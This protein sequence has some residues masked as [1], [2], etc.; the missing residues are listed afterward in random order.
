[1]DKQALVRKHRKHVV[2]IAWRSVTTDNCTPLSYNNSE[3]AGTPDRARRAIAH[4]VVAVLPEARTS[5]APWLAQYEARSQEG[6]DLSNLTFG[7]LGGTSLLAVEAAWRSS[8]SVAM[9][10]TKSGAAPAPPHLELTADDFLRGTLEEAAVTLRHILQMRLCLANVRT[11]SAT[12]VGRAD[13]GLV[14]TDDKPAEF[15]APPA[16]AV[17]QISHASRKRGRLEVRERGRVVQ[18]RS[19]VAIG[20]AGASVRHSPACSGGETDVTRE[21]RGAEGARVEL[22]IRW[23]SCLSKCIDATPLLVIPTDARGMVN[24]TR[25]G[26]SD[27]AVSMPDETPADLPECCCHSKPGGSLPA[28]DAKGSVVGNTTL[29]RN[30]RSSTTQ[31]ERGTVYVGSH[32]GDF[33]ALNLPTGER[34]W[35][36]T[37]NGRIESGAACSCDGLMVFV[38]CHDRH[39]YAI[40]R[41][42]GTLSWSFE[43]GDAIKCTPV[44]M[45]YLDPDEGTMR[46]K[47]LPVNYGTV[48]VGSHDGILRSLRE[49]DGE[50]KWSFDCGGALFASPA[51]SADSR[52]VYAAT[53]KGRVVALDCSTLVSTG[54]KEAD[55]ATNADTKQRRVGLSP[56]QPAI[57]W[58]IHLPA[59]CFS[60]P[61]VCDS[62]GSVVL[63]CVDGGLY[64]LSS[65]GE[66]VWVCRRGEKP[67]FSSP[68]LLPSVRKVLGRT[69]SHELETRVIWGCHDG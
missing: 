1:M 48:L 64:C 45:P 61:A 29:C 41:Q 42:M 38:G 66:Q 24:R 51:H 36:F 14:A 11:S 63:G 44:C 54:T 34:E 23:S 16:G 28:F 4:G 3:I 6:P 21:G 58:D 68:C 52:V 59:P 46:E 56:K 20:R 33:Q 18:S 43:T 2:G 65:N 49:V 26:C 8:L 39:L 32:S 12:A 13:V 47:R 22:N 5:V 57:R 60:T 37:A 35:A 9:L 27:K 50:L 62:N 67:V 15:L 17:Q 40:D 69:E 30:L 25:T 55:T 31:V 7:Q 10:N 53:T 19:F